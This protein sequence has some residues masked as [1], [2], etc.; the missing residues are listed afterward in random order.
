MLLKNDNIKH[1]YLRPLQQ[2]LKDINLQLE[3]FFFDS[4]NVKLCQNNDFYSSK[5]F[6]LHLMQLLK[7]CFKIL[8]F[9]DENELFLTGITVSDIVILIICQNIQM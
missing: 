4:L 2:Y 3:L 7:V 1:D 9:K 5:T 8:Q 6:H